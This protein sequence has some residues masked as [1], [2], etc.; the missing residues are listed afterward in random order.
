MT[1]KLT[2]GVV[3]KVSFSCI[4]YMDS[5]GASSKLRSCWNRTTTEGGSGVESCEGVIRVLVRFLGPL[6]SEVSN[7]CVVNRD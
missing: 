4:L 6:R 3:L 2:S 7:C 1:F 5:P